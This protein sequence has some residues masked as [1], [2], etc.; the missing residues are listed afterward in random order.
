M[1]KETWMLLPKGKGKL[2]W[3]L[4]NL[5]MRDSSSIDRVLETL[6]NAIDDCSRYINKAG[7]ADPVVDSEV[8]IIEALLGTCYVTCQ[9]FISEIVADAETIQGIAEDRKSP[10][11]CLPAIKNRKMKSVLC[12]L[13]PKV[14]LID[15][16]ANYFKHRCEWKSWDAPHPQQAKALNVLKGA[17]VHEFTDGNLRTVSRKLGNR[18]FGKTSTFLIILR[19]WQKQVYE[20]IDKEMQKTR[21]LK[22]SSKKSTP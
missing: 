14:A 7:G 4:F 6:G 20:I 13:S 11:N 1:K 8:P 12:A 16:A 19:L 18:S 5:K 21:T 17:M 3:A 10:L 22:R 9:V 15:A 2:E